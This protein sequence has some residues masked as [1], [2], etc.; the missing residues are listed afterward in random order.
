MNAKLLALLFLL[1]V[2]AAGAVLV[3]LLLDY[4]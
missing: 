3:G 2:I 1:L 4:W